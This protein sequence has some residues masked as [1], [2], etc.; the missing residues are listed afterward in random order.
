MAVTA[1]D[2]GLKNLPGREADLGGDA[3]GAQVLGIDLRPA[4]CV[5]AAQL[6]GDPEVVED[7]GGVGLG[8]HCGTMR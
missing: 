4:Q 2:E 3:D 7:A 5:V 8:G 6:V 1:G